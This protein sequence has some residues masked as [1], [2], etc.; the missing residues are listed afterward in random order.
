MDPTFLLLLSLSLWC[1]RADDELVLQC[2]R[3]KRRKQWWCKEWVRYSEVE[4]GHVLA[5]RTA[6][7]SVPKAFSLTKPRVPPPQMLQTPSKLPGGLLGVEFT[8]LSAAPGAMDGMMSWHHAIYCVPALTTSDLPGG[9]TAHPGWRQ[10]DLCHPDGWWLLDRAPWAG[11]LLGRG[12]A[13]SALAHL[14]PG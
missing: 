3:T 13:G 7:L 2:S 9:K 14:P 8:L 6:S 5:P 12:C 4:E 11:C 10:H 1:S